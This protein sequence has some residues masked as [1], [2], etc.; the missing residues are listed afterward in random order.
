MTHPLRILVP[1]S[2]PR[3]D[4]FDVKASQH[5]EDCVCLADICL[6][7][8]RLLDKESD[9]GPFRVQGLHSYG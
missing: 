3:L 6:E 5:M 8:V 9:S 7:S 4:G 1:I 2:E